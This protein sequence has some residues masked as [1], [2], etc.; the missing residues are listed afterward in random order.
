M[1]ELLDIGSNVASFGRSGHPQQQ[2]GLMNWS[3]PVHTSGDKYNVF[4]SGRNTKGENFE[5]TEVEVEISGDLN[6]TKVFWAI[7][8]ALDKLVCPNCDKH[9]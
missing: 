1:L 8:K 9:F 5:P 7:Y 4:V 2:L 3:N 6:P